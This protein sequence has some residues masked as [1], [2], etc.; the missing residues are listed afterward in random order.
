VVEREGGSF[1][2]FFH[3]DDWDPPIVRTGTKGDDPRR[4]P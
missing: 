3:V 4:T 2:R 1:D